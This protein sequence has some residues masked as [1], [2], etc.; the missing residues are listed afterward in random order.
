LTLQST[1]GTG[2]S[3]SI[4]F[5]TGSQVTAM[6]VNTAG[7]V[8]ANNT[9]VMGSSFLRNRIINGDM[10]IDQRNNGASVTPTLDG[11]YSV[12]RFVVEISVA[13]KFSMQQVTTAPAGFTNS[14]KITSLSSYT[15]LAADYFAFTQKI[16][17]YNFSDL[18][19]GSANAKTITL[20]FQVYSSLTGTFGGSIENSAQNRSYPFSYSIA[21]ANTWTS[22]SIT[23]P[24]DTTG[25]WLT[26][27]GIGAWVNF[28]LGCGSNFAGTA[29]TWQAANYVKPTGA[30][31]VVGTSGATLYL[32]G[33]QFEIGT[34]ATPFERQIYS[35]QLQQCQRYFLS[36]TA[37][38]QNVTS[39]TNGSSVSIYYQFPVPMRAA[40]TL[41]TQLTNANYSTS[42]TGN[43][44][45]FNQP[46]IV[47]LTKIGTY[48]VSFGSTYDIGVLFFLSATLSGQATGIY[49]PSIA[50]NQ[51][52]AEL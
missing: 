15:S 26:T 31:S 35:A 13:S 33:V 16:E 34:V 22:I 48:T 50:A 7:N 19:F 52:S 17:G 41:I 28:D 49:A 14:V 5:K 32:T 29:N 27:N 11:T 39:T 18:S 46:S 37:N 12:D 1:S 45:C 42:P 6:T 4:I 44:W 47:N 9:V 3:D 25:T 40:P 2:T 8:V 51:F 21:S 24:G 23:I 20:S 38:Q 36:Q 30:V 10:R 43:Q